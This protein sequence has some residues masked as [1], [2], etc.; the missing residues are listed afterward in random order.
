VGGADGVLR[1]FGPSRTLEWASG[2]ARK[3]DRDRSE[4]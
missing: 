1:R 4:E 3:V 2:G